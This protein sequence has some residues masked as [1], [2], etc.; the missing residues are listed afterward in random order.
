MRLKKYSSDISANGRQSIEK[1]LIVQR[2]SKWQLQEII[3][4]IFYITKNRYVWRDLP[5]EFPPWQT[6]YWYFRKWAKEGIWKYMN[7]CLTVDTEKRK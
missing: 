7:A 1:I 2:K 6:V 5:G 3:N 4:A